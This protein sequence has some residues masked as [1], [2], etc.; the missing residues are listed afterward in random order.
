MIVKQILDRQLFLDIVKNQEYKQKDIQ[1][2]K[3]FSSGSIKSIYEYFSLLNKRYVEYFIIEKNNKILIT[4]AITEDNFI[5]FFVTSNL[6]P[7]YGIE[8]VK[9][10]KYFVKE[11]LN[12]RLVLYIKTA[13][14]YKEAIKLNKLVG[15]K[16]KKINYD[17]QYSV[18]FIDRRL[19]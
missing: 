19:V 1:E 17:Y 7:R 16:A 2:I 15:F 14:W 4:S 10:L 6:E 13:I 12:A 5:H 9:L 11:I 3:Q 8:L 18:W